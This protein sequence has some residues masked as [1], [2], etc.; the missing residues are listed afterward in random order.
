MLLERER[1]SACGITFPP[2]PAICT[3]KN[4]NENDISVLALL[5]GGLVVWCSEPLTAIFHRRKISSIL[6]RKSGVDREK[7]V[8]AMTR[9]KHIDMGWIR[10]SIIT[11]FKFHK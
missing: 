2:P 10:Q 6:G 3:L 8:G 5:V 7:A 4:E 1:E 11:L 9:A